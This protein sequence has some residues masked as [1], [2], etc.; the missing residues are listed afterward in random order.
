MSGPLVLSY[1]YEGR[2]HE[3]GAYSPEEAAELVAD[4]AGAGIADVSIYDGAEYAREQ[5]P[6]GTRVLCPRKYWRSPLGTV[7]T[8]TQGSHGGQ[9][10]G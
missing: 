6:P 1:I 4:L 2:R 5:F 7:S 10:G 9:P 8:A 3:R